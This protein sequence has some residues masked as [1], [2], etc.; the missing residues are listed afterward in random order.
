MSSGRAA[1]TDG[2]FCLT[3]PAAALR[4]LAKVAW[5]A[6][7]SEALSRAKL[8]RGMKTSPRTSS[9]LVRPSSPLSDAGRALMVR[10]FWVMSS[11]TRPS[12]RVA[13][14]AKRPRV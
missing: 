13:P 2:S 3:A 8:S 11:P 12:P 5:P 4:G 9:D 14:R 7:S 6:S 10:R 1:V